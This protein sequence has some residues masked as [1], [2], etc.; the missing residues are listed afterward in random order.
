[1]SVASMMR[2]TQRAPRRCQECSARKIRCNKVIPCEPCI[3]R[4]QAAR[5]TRETVIVRGRVTLWVYIHH[6]LLLVAFGRW[7]G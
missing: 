2:R 7:I 5:C 3:R 4:G 1:M 6:P